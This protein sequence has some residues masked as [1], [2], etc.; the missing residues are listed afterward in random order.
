MKPD[1]KGWALETGRVV[2]KEGGGVLW[3]TGNP[4]AGTP[5]RALESGAIRAG[6]LVEMVSCPS[7]A[8]SP[9]VLLRGPCA[10]PF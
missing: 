1:R 2:G 6:R 7:P 5:L 3:N 10:A 8:T 4:V 9:L